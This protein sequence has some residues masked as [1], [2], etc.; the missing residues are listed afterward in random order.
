MLDDCISDQEWKLSSLDQAGQQQRVFAADCAGIEHAR[1]DVD[2]RSPNREAGRVQ[3]SQ[4]TIGLQQVI[5]ERYE[6]KCFHAADQRCAVAREAELKT[7]V[8]RGVGDRRGQSL[9]AIHIES[10]IRVRKHQ[11]WAGGNLRTAI[12]GSGY[13]SVRLPDD[14]QRVLV[15]PIANEVRRGL[16][17]AVIYK[18]DFKTWWVRLLRERS[19]T[20]G[21]RCPIIVSS[22][23]NAE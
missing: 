10:G 7:I 6:A 2:L 15:V 13:S 1:L 3:I 18:N 12:P 14:G 22:D 5:L 19:Q 17:T 8:L 11:D 23:D 9:Q 20:R 4:A 21:E 16:R